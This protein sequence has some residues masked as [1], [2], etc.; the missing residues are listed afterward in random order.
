MIERKRER[1]ID[2]Y[3]M[4]ERKIMLITVKWASVDY[5]QTI[6][7]WLVS[8]KRVLI[9]IKRARVLISIIRAWVLISIM[10]KSVDYCQTIES[11]DYCQTIKSVD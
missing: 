4:R 6:E 7:C 3:I 8:N 1:H 10:S 5:C 2:R 9:S 11:V